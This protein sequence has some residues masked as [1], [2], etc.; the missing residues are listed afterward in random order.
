MMYQHDAAD[1]FEF[2][3]RS[4]FELLNR[5]ADAVSGGNADA[6]RH[7]LDDLMREVGLHFVHEEQLM[8]S[9]GY[10]LASE[11][12]RAH[13]ELLDDLEGAKHQL[14]ILSGI[15]ARRAVIDMVRARLLGHT[16]TMDTEY[17]PF[18]AGLGVAA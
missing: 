2:E 6:A 12:H 4:H 9:H 14:Q 7:L 10:P 1:Q 8:R 3:H 5:A 15:D 13:E 11:H 18:F 17:E 16:L